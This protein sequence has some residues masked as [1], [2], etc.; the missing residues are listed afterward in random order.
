MPSTFRD[1]IQRISPG[2]LL[3]EPAQNGGI[4]YIGARYL[5]SIALQ[6]DYMTDR[7]V[8]GIKRRFPTYVLAG[9]TQP[10]GDALAMIG[11]DRTIIQ[12]P[13]EPNASYGVRLTE[14]I[15]DL[16]LSGNAFALLKQIQGY[17]TP[18]YTTLKL[19]NNWGVWY[20][21]T[22]TKAPDGTLSQAQTVTVSPLVANIPNWNWDNTGPWQPTWSPLFAWSQFWVLIYCSGGQPFDKGPRWTD[23]GA[24][25]TTPGR[26]WG[27]TATSSQVASIKGIVS[28]WKAAHS[29]CRNIII[30]FDPAS[31]NQSAVGGAPLPDGTWG[32]WANPTGSPF[33]GQAARLPTARYWDGPP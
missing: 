14:W 15:D 18:A 32:R 26:T 21:L 20:Q 28:Q 2:W 8:E 9:Q 5:Y 25:W 7:A 31:F 16:K 6:A 10:D 29:K 19:V 27:T 33:G 1:M 3:G 22:T 4:D 30:A 23:V 24:K 13:N 12:G 17:L 11:R